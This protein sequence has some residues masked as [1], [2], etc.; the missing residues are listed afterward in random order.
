MDWL[1]AHLGLLTVCT[2]PVA[3]I[4]AIVLSLIKDRK[5]GTSSCGCNCAHC[6]MAGKCHQS[7]K[8]AKETPEHSDDKEQT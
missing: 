5:R 2:V 1:I 6:A 7:P 3:L 4:V 8:A